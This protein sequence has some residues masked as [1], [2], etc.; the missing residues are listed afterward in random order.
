MLPPCGLGRLF[1]NVSLTDPPYSPVI[2]GSS[3]KGKSEKWNKSENE[4]KL[5]EVFH[6]GFYHKPPMNMFGTEYC[7][8][9]CQLL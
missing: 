1:T 4:I 8:D 6:Y 7:V 2:L 5:E 3:E 9:Y